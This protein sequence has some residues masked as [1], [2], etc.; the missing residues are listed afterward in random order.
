[1]I[2]WSQR[3]TN[4]RNVAQAMLGHM[5]E[6]KMIP[7]SIHG[8]PIFSSPTTTK[9]PTCSPSLSLSRQ[10]LGFPWRLIQGQ[11]W[12]SAKLV[13]AFQCG[14]EAGE[15]YLRA[16]CV[17]PLFLEG[18]AGTQRNSGRGE[19]VRVVKFYAGTR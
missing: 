3:G 4:Y 19:F 16:S 10:P 15:L 6:I 12:G 11:S 2:Y 13:I 17:S 18:G 9:L 5:R 8:A 1:M 7:G 14:N